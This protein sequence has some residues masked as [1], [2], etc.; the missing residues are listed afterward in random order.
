MPLAPSTPEVSVV[1]VATSSGGLEETLNSVFGQS[2]RHLECIVVGAGGT[3]GLITD[4]RARLITLPEATSVGQLR[5]AG[6]DDTHSAYVCFVDAGEILDRHA[7]RNL[8]VAAEQS[9]A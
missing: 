2:L 3:R 8:L 4:A 9:A 6:V 5:N 7:L 1:V